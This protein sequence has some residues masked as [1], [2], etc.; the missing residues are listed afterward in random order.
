[1]EASW[2]GYLSMHFAQGLSHPA[3]PSSAFAG[4][5]HPPGHAWAPSTSRDRAARRP[6]QGPSQGSGCPWG[7]QIRGK[8]QGFGMHCKAL[9]QDS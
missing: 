3:H 5:W 7:G 1:M 8:G 6:S 2:E 9:S 4:A